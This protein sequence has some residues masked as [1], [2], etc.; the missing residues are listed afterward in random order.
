MTALRVISAEDIARTLSVA[1]AVEVL[2]SLFGTSV[3]GPP[4]GR[5]HLAFAD[6]ELLIMSAVHNA[7]VGSSFA[8]SRS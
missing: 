8:E 6:G 2:G 7:G 5:Q 1:Q 4:A 3:D